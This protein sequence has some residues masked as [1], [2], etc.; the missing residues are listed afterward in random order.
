MRNQ[1]VHGYDRI[2]PEIVWQVVQDELL[3]LVAEL[4]RIEREA[5]E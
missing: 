4:Q 2:D 5:E 3:P 1:I